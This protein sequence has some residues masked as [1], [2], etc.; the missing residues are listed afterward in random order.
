VAARG[1]RV[2]GAGRSRINRALIH[3][4]DAYSIQASPSATRAILADVFGAHT[5]HERA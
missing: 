5:M 4:V 3:P 2:S 1:A